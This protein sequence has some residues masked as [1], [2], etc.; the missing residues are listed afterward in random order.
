MP[1]TL[2]V[3]RIECIQY[4]IEHIEGLGLGERLACALEALRQ[5]LTV[6][7]VHHIIRC[8][9][10]IEEVVDLHNV[11]VVQLAQAARFLIEFFTLTIETQ[12]IVRITYSH[13]VVVIS[14]TH[15]SHE[16]FLHGHA[17]VEL[18][19]HHHIGVA[20]AARGKTFLNSVFAHLQGRTHWKHIVLINRVLFRHSIEVISFKCKIINYLI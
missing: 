19:V 18:G 14:F 2:T 6:D 8:L 12:A 4:L 1:N 3:N 16:E 10:L 9:V 20:K 7:I 11:L 17:F 13:G 15:A 5:R